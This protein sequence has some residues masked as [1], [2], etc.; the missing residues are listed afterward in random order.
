MKSIKNEGFFSNFNL[1]DLPLKSLQFDFEHREA[2]M[3]LEEC[4]ENDC[5]HNLV[6]TFKNVS[7]YSFKYPTERFQ[8]AVLAVHSIVFEKKLNFYRAVILVDMPEIHSSSDR[9]LG[10]TVGEMSITFEDL[11]VIGGLSPEAM[12]FKMREED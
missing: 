4:D 9:K 1:Y 3:I 2:V 5:V 11:E 12:K 10:F 6:L 8:F 7:E